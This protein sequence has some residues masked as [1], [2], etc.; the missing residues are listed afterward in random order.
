[1]EGSWDEEP[2]HLEHLGIAGLRQLQQLELTGEGCC[3]FC[4]MFC[5]FRCV[6]RG[7]NTFC[8]LLLSL[9]LFRADGVTEE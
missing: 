5:C 9:R 4:C 1:M 2:W 8:Y 6:L 3:T 7:S